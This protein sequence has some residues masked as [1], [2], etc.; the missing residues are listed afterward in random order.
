MP[1]QGFLQQV[2]GLQHAEDMVEPVAA[3]DEAGKFGFD[4]ALASQF[5]A[6]VEV[7]D[8]HFPARRHDRRDFLLV[9]AQDV[10]D[11]F[12]LAFVE[13]AGFGTLL[14]QHLDFIVGHRRLFLAARPEQAQDGRR[15]TGQYHHQGMRHLGQEQHR[16]GDQ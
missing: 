12:L 7:D 16:T 5:I 4:D 10:G 1:G 13:D 9:Q 3:N 2:A 8:E 14:H 15:G 6:F 11:D